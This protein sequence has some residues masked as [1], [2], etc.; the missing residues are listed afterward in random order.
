MYTYINLFFHLLRFNLFISYTHFVYRLD[1][2]FSKLK[3]LINDYYAILYTFAQF[4]T[5]F[6]THYIFF[7]MITVDYFRYAEVHGFYL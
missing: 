3:K 6:S 7:T 1:K 4:T 2:A 5:A